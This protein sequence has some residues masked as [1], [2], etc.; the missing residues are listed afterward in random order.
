MKLHIVAT[1]NRKTTTMEHIAIDSELVT[2]HIIIDDV[3]VRRLVIVPE[4]V[5]VILIAEGGEDVHP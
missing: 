5:E 2:L 1:D 4:G 3:L